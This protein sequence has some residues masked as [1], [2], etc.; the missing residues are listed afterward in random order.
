M[1]PQHSDLFYQLRLYWDHSLTMRAVIAGVILYGLLTLAIVAVETLRE[2][3]GKPIPKA[4][5][6]QLVGCWGACFFV[7]AGV[8]LVARMVEPLAR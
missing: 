2:N 1:K 7:V 5:S 8:L 3:F 4:V 6:Y